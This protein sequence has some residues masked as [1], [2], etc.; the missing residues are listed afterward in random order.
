MRCLIT[1][2]AGFIGSHLS[3]RLLSQ[4]HHVV[5]L[6]AVTDE[7]DPAAKRSNL[8]AIRALGDMPFVQADIRDTAAVQSTLLDN[9]IDTIFHLAAMPGVRRSVEAPR[10]CNDINVQGTISVLEAARNA[11][12]RKIIFASS[13]S[14]YGTGAPIPFDESK[15]QTRP[16]SPYAASKLA[17]EH[18]CHAYSHLYGISITCLRLFT[19]YGPR[20]RP[21]L[22]I[23]K[24]IRAILD[25]AEIPLFGD[26]SSRRDYT[27]CADAVAALAAAA[28]VPS[29][30]D[31]INIASGRAI[32]LRDVL[33]HI[34]AATN[35]EPRIR[36]LPPQAGD[37]DATEANIEKA[38]ELLRYSPSTSFTEG[39]DAQVRW[40]LQR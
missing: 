34:V 27:Y 7:Y 13:S 38:R 36:H 31:V 17:G 37:L 2:G 10:L 1:G 14:V 30:F 22:A 19:V 20:Q 26:G 35:R 21:D 29:Q 9:R 11:G 16:I 40:T 23:S 12:V 33:N 5:V 28:E 39:I 18:L 8:S 3:E 4:G 15:T 32:F 6:D 25:G 24:F